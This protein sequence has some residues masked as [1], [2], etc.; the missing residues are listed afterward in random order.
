MLF[1]SLFWLNCSEK[2]EEPTIITSINPFR[3]IIEPLV[4]PIIKVHNLMPPGASPHTF[5]LKPSDMR[6]VESGSL[7][8]VGAKNLDPWAFELFAPNMV[9]LECLISA[10]DVLF[11]DP[12]SQIIDP[13]FW[14]DPLIVKTMVPTI[15]QQISIFFPE[16]A[17]QILS[18]QNHFIARLD[19]LHQAI[20]LTLQ[21]FKGTN[22]I[23]SHPFFQYYLHRYEFGIIT[24]IEPYH[25][26][27][28]TIKSLQAKIDLVPQEHVKLILAHR[29]HSSRQAKLIAES[30]Q[31]PLVII[32]PLGSE[33]GNTTY[34][35]MLWSNTLRIAEA[36]K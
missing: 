36:L 3:Q 29:D 11:I 16:Y 10:R 17:G 9:G 14:T 30:T 20:A 24:I 34:D 33:R 19:S 15:G 21:P 28:G 35:K 18:N 13:H 22:V 32:D 23:L 31:I 6:Q 25:G 27:L 2:S 1:I 4:G 12:D 26:N 7:F 5:R 8:F